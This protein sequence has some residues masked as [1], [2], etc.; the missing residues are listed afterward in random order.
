[1][2]ILQ[3]VDQLEHVLNQG[4]RMPFTS[5]LVVN[6]EECLR[7]IDQMRISVPS[8][9]KESERMIAERDRIMNEAHARAEAMVDQAET[10]ARRMV[11]QHYVV[12][13]A[14]REAERVIEV[15]QKEAM[16]LVQ[17]AE[18]YALNVLRELVQQLG[19]SI[20]QAE[21][22]IRAIEE[23]QAEAEPA[24]TPELPKPVA[25][26]NPS[27]ITAPPVPIQEPKPVQES[28]PVEES[29]PKPEDAGDT[30]AQE[31]PEKTE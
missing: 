16:R 24:K 31:P 10:E 28:E 6:E 5:S 4:W 29:E 19:S 27:T 9:I 17:E 11:S 15:G 12:Q 8:A 23:S 26:T 25:A 3:L 30:K 13:E 1:M 2:E 14:R 21:N 18:D 22:G 20:R 7:L